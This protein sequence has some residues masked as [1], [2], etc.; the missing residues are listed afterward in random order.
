MQMSN[1]N[2]RKLYSPE[3]ER[4]GFILDDEEIIEL[5]NI[6]TDPALT[7]V[8][9]PEEFDKHLPR[10]TASWHT[11]THADANLSFEDYQFFLSWPKLR[12][13]IISSEAVW[14]YEVT[15]GSVVVLHET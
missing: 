6:S 8:F 5:E 14:S 10:A 11:H 4:I 12:H 2:L 9:D 1:E 7:F 15:N 13:F 3:I